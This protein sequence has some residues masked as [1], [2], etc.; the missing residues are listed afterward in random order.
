M[1]NRA[2]RVVFPAGAFL[3]RLAR[4]RAGNTL[5]M[6]A[7]ALMPMMALVGGGI[8]MGRAYLSQSRLQQACDA[9]GLAAR[10][11]L[12]TAAP[13]DGH[14]PEAVADTGQRF[15]N[16]NFRAGSYGTQQRDFVMTLETDNS[17]TG[18]AR[19]IVPTTIM[20]MFGFEQ[21]PV[22]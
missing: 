4:D 21:V 18:V 20:H 19:V 15:F 2:Q 7:A 1:K 8:D 12:G 14:I 17:I 22:A 13:T 16:I 6:I 3:R 9:G 10:K 5:A 11:S